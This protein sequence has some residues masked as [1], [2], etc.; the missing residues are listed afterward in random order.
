MEKKHIVLVGAGIFGVRHLEGLLNWNG[1]Y[2]VT[3]LDSSC[4][5]LERCKLVGESGVVVNYV[6]TLEAISQSIDLVVIA[7]T[8]NSHLELIDSFSKRGVKY[9]LL[10]KLAFNSAQDII[11]ASVIVENFGAEVWVNCPRRIYPGY[12]A[13]KDKL[14]NF[15]ID[16]MK[17]TGT[18]YGL[19]CNG[20]HYLD[21]FCFLLG[22]DSYTLQPSGE[23]QFG[24]SKRF[25]YEEIRGSLEGETVNGEYIS[26][27]CDEID[28]P[29]QTLIEIDF[30]GGRIEIVEG[31]GRMVLDYQGSRESIELS[32][33]FQSSM[34]GSVATMILDGE[35]PG[36]TPFL[37]S[38]S[39]HRS[40]IGACYSA[41]SKSRGGNLRGFVPLT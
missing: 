37:E 11:E 9:F 5:A 3:V 25:G 20:I 15:H 24:A 32:S 23:I 14:K 8:A 41:Y 31:K 6:S 33:I 1:H 10:E 18:G 34:T 28:A 2:S 13:L 39:I 27:S 40:F 17:L 29:P 35:N 38:M 21:L 16:Q 4:A 36:L 22:T 26:L 19:G 30:E 7:T 12:I